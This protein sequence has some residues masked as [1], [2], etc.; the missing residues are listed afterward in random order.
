MGNNKKHITCFHCDEKG[1]YKSK[2]PDFVEEEEE[3]MDVANM[4][5]NSQGI[6][7]MMASPT[8]QLPP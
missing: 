1:H 3:E 5:V 8:E 4:M 2:C 7:L 6:V